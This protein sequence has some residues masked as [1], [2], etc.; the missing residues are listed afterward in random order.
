[1]YDRFPGEFWVHFRLARYEPLSRSG[2]VDPNE[3]QERTLR[4]LTAAVAARPG[5][6][7]A[8]TALAMHLL[9]QRKD[10]PAA[11]RILRGAAEVDPTS[12]WP[13]LVLGMAAADE[14][15]LAESLPPLRECV[16][17]DPD[18]GFFAIHTTI[19]KLFPRGANTPKPLPDDE[20]ARFIDG[21]I[22]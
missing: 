21:L 18:T 13:H 12:P 3:R 11:R 6:A 1:A 7:V 17:I 5:S 4:H 2:K 9:E 19:A 10:D 14:A 20:L 8:R 15:N 22:A 16:R